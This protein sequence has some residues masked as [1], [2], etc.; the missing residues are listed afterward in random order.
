MGV[1]DVGPGQAASADTDFWGN[2]IGSEK[3]LHHIS[4]MIHWDGQKSTT[5]AIPSMVVE[6]GAA[7]SGVHSVGAVCHLC[8][9]LYWRSER[10]I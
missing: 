2:S 4:R 7:N 5:K 6:C 9:I 8:T 1:E 3:T 10:F